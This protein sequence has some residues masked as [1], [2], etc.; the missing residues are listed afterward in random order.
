M[1]L[2]ALVE[3]LGDLQALDG[4][5]A[6][7]LRRLE[8]LRDTPLWPLLRGRWLGHA[9]HPMLTDVPIGF[10]TSAVVLDAVGGEAGQSGA[11]RLI[12]LGALASVPTAFAG[13]ADWSEASRKARRQGLVHASANTVALA[14]FLGSLAARRR[15]RVLGKKLALVGA[16]A[17]M[18]GGYI[19]GHLTYAEGVGV[20]PRA[21]SEPADPDA[22]PA[23]L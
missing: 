16:T 1:G 17:L 11:D 13:M 10:W 21:A 9:L 7:L 20:D 22:P 2:H 5:D 23:S 8:P 14:F 4:S 18:G 3:R 12:A 6:K 15:N 19:G